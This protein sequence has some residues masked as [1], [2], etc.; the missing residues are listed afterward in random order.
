MI[1]GGM[2]IERKG[3]DTIT[4]PP[5]RKPKILLTTNYVLPEIG[6]SYVARQHIVEFGNY[7][8]LQYHRG[9]EPY[10]VLGKILFNT[11]WSNAD[12]NDFYNYIFCCA[13]LYLRE[14]L[15]RTSL[16][17]YKRK[18]I[19]SLIEGQKDFGFVEW[20]EDWIRSDRLENNCH[21]N[22][23][24]TFEALYTRAR[25]DLED[26]KWTVADF[27][28]GVWKY[29]KQMGYGFNDQLAHKGNNMSS[30]RNRKGSRDNQLEWICITTPT[31]K[32]PT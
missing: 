6:T 5:R 18:Q 17:S 31:D 27:K 10:D 15:V 13:Q 21:L 19:K 12:W 22:D 28:V 16:D 1:T 2:E 26:M 7:W 30:R 24:V 32:T 3:K 29:C 23:G 9:I 20:L 14:G 4:I 8:N 25:T 11:D